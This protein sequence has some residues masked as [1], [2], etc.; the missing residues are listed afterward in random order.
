MRHSG[1]LLAET[2]RKITSKRSVGYL[3]CIRCIALESHAGGCQNISG[4]HQNGVH[5]ARLTCGFVGLEGAATV[6]TDETSPDVP[7]AIDTKAFVVS[8]LEGV[9]TVTG[10]GLR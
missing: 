4:K 6:D 10:E 5:N 8:A 7:S 9:L 2:L 3:A 1:V